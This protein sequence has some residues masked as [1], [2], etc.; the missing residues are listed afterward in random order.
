LYIEPSVRATP[1]ADPANVLVLELFPLPAD[2]LPTGSTAAVVATT[3]NTAV[4][5]VR[6]LGL[7]C[8]TRTLVSISRH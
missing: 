5:Q 4:R 8:L 2:A 3:A 7:L 6:P 1:A